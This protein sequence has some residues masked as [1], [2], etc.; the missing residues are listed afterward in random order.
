M[1]F[2][3]LNN[4]LVL[5]IFAFLSLDEWLPLQSACKR[6]YKLANDQGL[7]Q[8]WCINKFPT[9]ITSETPLPPD[10][11]Y[12]W[13]AKCSMYDLKDSNDAKYGY[14][15]T[16]EFLY[17][18]S[19][20]GVLETGIHIYSA[21][22]K[23]RSG[24]FVNKQMQGQ[25]TM[26]TSKF[27]YKGE[28]MNDLST[29]F[30][31]WSSDGDTYIG[32]YVDGRKEGHGKYTWSTGFYYEGQW[33]KGSTH[34]SGR[35]VNPNGSSYVGHFVGGRH[36]LGTFTRCTNG[37][38]DRVFK[39]MWQD[40]VPIGCE[41]GLVYYKCLFCDV[42]VCVSCFE[43]HKKCVTKKQWC[44]QEDTKLNCKHGHMKLTDH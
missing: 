6:F 28:F 5:C 27:T 43:D 24:T 19:V 8:S 34:G 26:T 9:L 31:S 2:T 40:D 10:A 16:S 38:V 18:R 17:I 21:T 4:Q 41:F 1:P 12:K 13:L 25:G 22:M 29:G 37:Q 30:G 11:D 42:D 15:L 20:Q 35:H 14:M 44:S 7:L 3:T 39:G 36:G 33:Q 23:C 32:Y